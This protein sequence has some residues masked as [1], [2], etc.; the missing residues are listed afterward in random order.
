MRTTMSSGYT[1]P[2][3]ISSVSVVSSRLLVLRS[4]RRCEHPEFRR[5]GRDKP[6]MVFWRLLSRYFERSAL[7]SMSVALHSSNAFL[8]ISARI[9]YPFGRTPSA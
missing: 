9:A 5:F 2:V 3:A 6:L 8:R 7:A 4:P 1:L